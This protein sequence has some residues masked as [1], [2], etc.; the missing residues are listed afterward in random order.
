MSTTLMRHGAMYTIKPIEARALGWVGRASAAVWL[1]CDTAPTAQARVCV[2]VC[3][4]VCVR[5]GVWGVNRSEGLVRR[6]GDRR[7]GVG[8]E[9]GWRWWRL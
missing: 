2:P 8:G 5:V 1:R 7:R 6:A 9:V 4:C 3:V